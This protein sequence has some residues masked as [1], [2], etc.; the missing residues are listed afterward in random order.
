[1]KGRILILAATLLG[2]L[3]LEGQAQRG[4]V[5]GGPLKEAVLSANRICHDV[6]MGSLMGQ[7][8]Q[9]FIAG[10]SMEYVGS[11]LINPYLGLGLGVGAQTYRYDFGTTYFPVWLD[12]KGYLGGQGLRPY[13][14]LGAGYGVGL[15]AEDEFEGASVETDGGLNL[16][17][18]FGFI[19]PIAEAYMLTVG[20]GYQ[21][22]SGESRFQSN[23]WWGG[24]LEVQELQFRR[25]HLQIG[26]LF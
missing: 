22:Q 2:L 7:A 12:A 16:R 19:A 13:I 1:M 5:P 23:P 6:R 24:Q 25:I 8:E 4:E 10:V 14:Q 18:G 20:L 9:G 21:Y 3:P 17:S 26:I 11:Y 15:D